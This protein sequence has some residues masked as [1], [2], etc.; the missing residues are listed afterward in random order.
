MVSMRW[1]ILIYNFVI[2]NDSRIKS[3]ITCWGTFVKHLSIVDAS[4]DHPILVWNL[5]GYSYL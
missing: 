3:F 1:P 2:E 5:G 4:S